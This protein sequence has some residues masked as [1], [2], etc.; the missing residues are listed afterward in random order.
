MRIKLRRDGECVCHALFVGRRT[1]E[2]DN[3]I[4]DH[5]SN[6]LRGTETAASVLLHC[7]ADLILLKPSSTIFE[8]AL[9]MVRKKK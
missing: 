5:F 1:G 9:A 2:I 3:D 4:L 7:E 6:L 8:L